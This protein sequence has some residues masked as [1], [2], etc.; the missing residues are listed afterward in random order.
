MARRLFK[1]YHLVVFDPGGRIGWAYFAVDR[2]AFMRPS[3]KLLANVIEWHTGEFRETERENL[4][5]CSDLMKRARWDN[6]GK[7]IETGVVT[8]DFEL[9]QMT[10][11]ENLLSPV[12]QNAII[13][14]E[15]ERRCGLGVG[16]LA[17]PVGFFKQKRQLRLGVTRE[18]LKEWG[19]SSKG[20][21]SFAAMQHAIT[22]LRR[23]KQEANK[24]PW[25]KRER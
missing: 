15:A 17:Y 5:R 24:R 1:E 7:L 18:R 2:D 12:R 3:A 8:E 6:E 9:T 11:G 23:I 16:T 25:P 20:K 14:W 21:D 22:W 10:G 4:Q 13:Q 19:F